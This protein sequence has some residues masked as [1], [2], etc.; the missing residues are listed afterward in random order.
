MALI[1]CGARSWSCLILA[2]VWI[3]GFG[4]FRLAGSAIRFRASTRSARGSPPTVRQHVARSYWQAC[5]M[6]NRFQ[7]VVSAAGPASGAGLAQCLPG[8]AM[9]TRIV[10][11]I[12]V[13][14]RAKSSHIA[15]SKGT[16]L[17]II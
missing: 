17:Q 14:I 1:F 11:E 4:D 15:P 6:P 16:A 8:I 13:G 12:A 9:P 2:A 7:S 10:S 5:G 3:A